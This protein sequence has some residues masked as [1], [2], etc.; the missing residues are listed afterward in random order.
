[1]FL[2]DFDFCWKS[3]TYKKNDFPIL[4]NTNGSNC[5]EVNILQKL[6]I[7]EWNCDLFITNCTGF[8]SMETELVNYDLFSPGVATWAVKTSFFYCCN[9]S[10]LRT[11]ARPTMVICSASSSILSGPTLVS[12]S[13]LSLF[14]KQ[15]PRVVCFSI[16][17]NPNSLIS[18]R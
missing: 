1:M 10:H 18:Q 11:V 16:S 4:G 2:R 8:K 3:P 5:N 17:R 14:A 15:N 7:A 6:K 12:I 9:S 13:D